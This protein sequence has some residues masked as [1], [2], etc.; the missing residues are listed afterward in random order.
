MVVHASDVIRV[1]LAAFLACEP[2]LEVVAPASSA[3]EA[4]DTLA[5]NPADVI[6]LDLDLPGMRGRAA[7]AEIVER[8]N[9]ASVVV[10]AAVL[11]DTLIQA[12]LRAGARGLLERNAPAV[13]VIEAVRAAARGEPALSPDVVG[14]LVEWVRRSPRLVLDDR[15]LGPHEI[16]AISLAAE[17]LK[18]REMAARLGVSEATVKLYVRSAMRKLGVRKRSSAVALCMRRGV[19]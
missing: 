10:L 17:G 4:V 8:A 3:E 7:C 11:D 6:V 18:S 9:H 1:G 13:E 12:C 2:D 15:S 16:E 5:T 14:R 19:I